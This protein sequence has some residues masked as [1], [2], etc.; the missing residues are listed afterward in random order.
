MF[1][2]KAR[3]HEP[4]DAR[5]S[6]ADLR[7]PEAA[8]PPATRRIR[9]AINL[10]SACA[11]STLTTFMVAA[12]PAS[13]HSG[14]ELITSFGSFHEPFGLAVDLE[15]GNVYVANKE[16]DTVDIFGATGGNPAGGVPSQITALRFDPGNV[17]PAGVAVDNSCYEHEPRLTG[18]TCEEFDPSYNDVYIEYNSP[19]AQPDSIQK[20][21]LS[22]EGRYEL[23]GEFLDPKEAADP[24]GVTVDAD[25]NV[26]FVDYFYSGVIE[27]KKVVEKIVAGGK[28]E[29]Q[30]KVKEV[31][32]PDSLV[33]SPGYVAVDSSN[34][35]YL[36]YPYEVNSPSEPGGDNG[37]AKLKIGAAG[38][39]ISEEYLTGYASEDRR[40]LAV[41]RVTGDVFVGAG[42]YFGGS[43]IAEYNSAGVLQETFGSVE[44]LGG[45]L[46][47]GFNDVSAIAVNPV[48]E[49]IYVAN[50]N[51]A[52]EDVVVFGP[53]V[54]LP[55]VGARQPVASTIARTS[56]LIS[57]SA[58]PESG[59]SASYYF[60]YVA[61]G[62]YEQGATDPYGEGGRTVEGVLPGGHAAETTEPVAVT[63]L[64][65]G[66]TY[67]Y[68]MV[69]SNATG[70]TDG[71]DEMFT[72]ASA[73]PPVLST[74]PADEVTAT[75]ATLTGVVAPRG[76]PT[77]YVFE[78]GTGTNYAGARLFGNAGDS[79]GEVA[80]SAG[81]QYLVPGVT[82]HYRLAA[83]S[84]DGTSYGQDQT[85][86]TP[87]VSSPVG[88]PASIPLI[89]SP[90]GGFP[91]IAGAITSLGTTKKTLTR[92]QMLAQAL[93]ACERKPKGPKRT[94]C[95]ANAHKQYRPL[96]K[97]KKGARN[98][99]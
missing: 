46:G 68:R 39:V 94:A 78:V 19:G 13:A 15:T 31:D 67:H 32:I 82:Y 62:E 93:K 37:V 66:T 85:F 24:L 11:L 18:K 95:E 92:A 1:A 26:Y 29:I 41:S 58:S 75:S 83:A 97:A 9:R 56:V 42:S 98:S 8:T 38:N 28:E 16:P 64:L 34:D 88:Q 23:V 25:G 99:R 70:T 73:T 10:G 48:T 91:S 4:Y 71:P 53:V 45:S 81:L 90:T 72:T 96:R 60:E 86:T 69:V 59:Q 76:L 44:P 87:N 33:H 65:P 36:S 52:D 2:L 61:S 27:F 43:E 54:G 63:G 14:R 12:V 84:F 51:P 20:F 89:A 35:I 57:G 40:P 6:R 21:R 49:R 7:G 74:G 50:P 77:S 22:A 55:V 30:E 5:L 47:K 17:T 80:V 3:R 79:T